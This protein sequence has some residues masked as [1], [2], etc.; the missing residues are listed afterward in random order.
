MSKMPN[1]ELTYQERHRNYTVK[2]YIESYGTI[3]ADLNGKETENLIMMTWKQAKYISDTHGGFI[4]QI[5]N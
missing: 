2:Q 1:S 3:Y 4:K 5:E